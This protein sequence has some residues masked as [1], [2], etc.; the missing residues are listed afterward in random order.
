ME[1]PHGILAPDV[2]QINTSSLKVTNHVLVYV[3][4][5][6]KHLCTLV[7]C[8]DFYIHKL[9]SIFNRRF[10]RFTNHGEREIQRGGV[11][12]DCVV[13]PWLKSWWVCFKTSCWEVNKFNEA[14]DLHIRISI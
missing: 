8:V 3:G 4:H 14:L 10:L 12:W 13:V 5:K 9:C 2:Q 11:G 6:V 7:Y 1:H